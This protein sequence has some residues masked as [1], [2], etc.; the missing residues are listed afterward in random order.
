MLNLKENKDKTLI[1]RV[2]IDPESG[3]ISHDCDVSYLL[4][5]GGPFYGKDEVSEEDVI[6]EIKDEK[7][8]VYFVRFEES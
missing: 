5:K 6:A 2:L 1:A 3:G 8:H 4:N 7:T